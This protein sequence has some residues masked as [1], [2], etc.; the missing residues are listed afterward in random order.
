MVFCNNNKC[1]SFRVILYLSLF[2]LVALLVQIVVFS[3]AAFT[4]PD[5]IFNDGNIMFIITIMTFSFIFVIH[6]MQI[7]GAYY[8]NYC[9][10]VTTV[11]FRVTGLLTGRTSAIQPILRI[12]SDTLELDWPFNW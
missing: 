1:D 2:D 3:I 8:G 9:L 11:V 10:L 4:W 7:C 12:V 6:I 5:E